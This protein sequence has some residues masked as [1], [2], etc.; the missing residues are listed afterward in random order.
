[1]TVQSYPDVHLCHAMTV[2]LC[3]AMTVQS[4]PGFHLC[5][6]MTVHLCHAMTVQLYPD[7]HL[8]H[9]M[10]VHL[11]YAMTVQLYPD[12]QLRHAMISASNSALHST[13]VIVVSFVCYYIFHFD[14]S[15]FYTLGWEVE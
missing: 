13:S 11:C 10:T 4:Y 6:A 5:H 1:M 15:D 7:V 3:Y 8:C 9:A 14:N 12:I 2:H